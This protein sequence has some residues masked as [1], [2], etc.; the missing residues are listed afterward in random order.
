MSHG[1]TIQRSA[2]LSDTQKDS[3]NEDSEEESF[4]TWSLKESDLY[5]I[6]EVY[7]R[8]TNPLVFY[9]IPV[10]VLA[11]RL[12]HFMRMNSIRCQ[13]DT[14]RARVVGCTPQASF[15][16][17]VWR[18]ND[19]TRRGNCNKIL[20]EV[21][22]RQGCCILTHKIRHALAHSLLSDN[23]PIRYESLLTS[24]R[25]LKPSHR[26]K[27]IYRTSP[28]ALPNRTKSYPA[29]YQLKDLETSL[30]LLESDSYNKQDLGM[31]SIAHMSDETR[32]A[33]EQAFALAQLLISRQ[34]STSAG[35]FDVGARL[36]NAVEDYIYDL[37]ETRPRVTD[38]SPFCYTLLAL[39]NA[40]ELFLKEMDPKAI[41][42]WVH[43]SP[44]MLCVYWR[45]IMQF[46]L[47]RFSAFQQ[48]PESA[49]LAAK[50]IRLLSSLVSYSGEG[51]DEMQA[52]CKG[53]TMILKDAYR[54]GKKFNASLE[55]EAS[56][57]SQAIRK[58]Q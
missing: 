44:P 13:Y 18:Q 12:S 53:L 23:D 39:S 22:R 15:L 20:M 19:P 14:E 27:T 57:L 7:P 28:R 47:K 40:A 58:F 51:T 49:A 50:C 5:P 37:E 30:E 48:F 31:E 25:Q 24:C 2:S 17:Q 10:D 46:L 54:Y 34:S 38:E 43:S 45:H 1:T 29:N 8:I 35:P 3:S 4:F 11:G 9:D 36:Q 42:L 16:V 32:V 41:F 6:P 55:R 52:L 21:T 33:K 56:E 26:I